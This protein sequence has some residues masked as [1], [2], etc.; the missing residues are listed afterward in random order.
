MRAEEMNGGHQYQPGKHAAGENG[1]CDSGADDVADAEIF[2]RGIRADGRAG[3]PFRLV[4]R[5]AGPGAEQVA[6]LKQGVDRTQAEAPEDA[7]G[8][9][10][11]MF[12]GEKNIRAGSAFGVGEMAVFLDDQFS[13]QRNHEEDAE[14]SA[15]QRQE[16]DA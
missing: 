2:R 11:A 3:E 8:E 6:I 5:R 7:A 13:S 16:K 1:T 9:G 15:E 12:A 14:P 10:S 4:I